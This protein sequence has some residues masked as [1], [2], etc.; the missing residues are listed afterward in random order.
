M[1]KVVSFYRVFGDGAIHEKILF[2]GS[3]EECETWTAE[4]IPQNLQSQSSIE[5]VNDGDYVGLDIVND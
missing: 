3:Q 4:N 2:I 5:D 1:K